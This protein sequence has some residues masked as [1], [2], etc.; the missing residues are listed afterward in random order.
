MVQVKSMICSH[1]KTIY[2]ILGRESVH[3][4]P[5]RMAP[6]IAL[7][8]IA[9]AKKPLRVLDPMMGSGTVLAV[10]RS[11]GHWAIGI[12]IDPLAVL[13]SRVWTTAVYVDEVRDK[14][15]E[16]LRRARETFATLATRDAYPR[17]ADQQTH[18]F[19]AYWFDDYARR[20]LASLAIAI[21]RVRDRKIRDVLWCG[22][23]RLIISKQSGASLAM[24]LSHSRPHK[25]FKRAPTKPFRRF[26][27]AVDRVVENCIDGR[28]KGR[29]PSP[30]IHEGDARRLPL[31]DAS[32]DLV[33]TSPPYLNAIDYRCHIFYNR[34]WRYRVVTGWIKNSVFNTWK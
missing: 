16:V 27:S 31:S 29:G 8:A 12:D 13:I 19:V 11:K 24:D 15:V 25:C 7:E 34:E 14:A 2:E 1:N 23:S 3:P 20:Q 6:G 33:L 22:F 32:I 18:R 26:L 21:S 10:A 4:F 5:A 9:D 30:C 28:T 17:P